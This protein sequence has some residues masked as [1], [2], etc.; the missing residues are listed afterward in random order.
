MINYFIKCQELIG[1]CSDINNC[2]DICK[3]LYKENY[4]F[5]DKPI[6]EEI[7]VSDEDSK[8]SLRLV[9]GV[10]QL[11]NEPIRWKQFA[12]LKRNL[13]SEIEGN[14]YFRYIEYGLKKYEQ[15]KFE[16]YENYNKQN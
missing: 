5:I 7:L 14:K 8:G 16:I 15:L 4:G 1:V 11:P 12:I 9:L 3:S 13:N 6:I 2:V 10:R